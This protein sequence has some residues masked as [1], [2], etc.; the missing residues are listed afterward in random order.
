MQTLAIDMDEVITDTGKKLREWYRR[1]HGIS[2]REEDLR[3]KDLKEVVCEAHYPLF[4][5]YLNT[6]GFFRD[7]DA[8]A[9]APEVLEQLNQR[10]TLYLVSAAMEFPRS[11]GDKF[12]WIMERL[13]FIHWRQ[14]CFCGSKALIQTD[15]MIDDRVRNFAAFQ[16]RK[17]LFSA[18][19]NLLQE[20]YERVNHWQD[21]AEKLL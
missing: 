16:G 8:M 13:P 1:D 15:I 18:H 12:D 17:L 19:H 21:V 10:Y 11:L 14:V 2:F 20:G 6:P 9:D 3:G 5:A 7:L 4:H